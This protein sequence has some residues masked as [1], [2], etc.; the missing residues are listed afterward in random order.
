MSHK[1]LPTYSPPPLHTLQN[2]EMKKST[3]E[4]K[5]NDQML[6]I[7]DHKNVNKS[8]YRL[9]PAKLESKKQ[10]KKIIYPG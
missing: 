9:S 2:E 5:E 6:R 7:S 10:D 8:K 1:T 4:C 3:L